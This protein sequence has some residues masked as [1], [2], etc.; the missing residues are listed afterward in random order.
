MAA[1]KGRSLQRASRAFV[2]GCCFCKLP[3]RDVCLSLRREEHC[4]E[5]FGWPQLRRVTRWPSVCVNHGWWHRVAVSARGH[6]CAEDD[7]APMRFLERFW[8]M[9]QPQK[10]CLKLQCLPAPVIALVAASP[11][12]CP[13]LSQASYC[14]CTLHTPSPPLLPAGHRAIVS[15]HRRP[16]RALPTHTPAHLRPLAAL[17]ASQLDARHPC[18]TR[19]DV[20][21][22][23]STPHHPPPNVPPPRLL[24]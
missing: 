13:G 5:L 2:A 9:V 12:F 10:A 1:L 24:Q 8:K 14:G 20:K 19:T 22:L 21:E 16:P 6:S 7:R 23:R 15:S 11:L 17:Q 4:S 18:S 3:R